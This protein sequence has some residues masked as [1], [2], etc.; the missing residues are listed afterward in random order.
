MHSIW[1]IARNTLAQ[2]LRMKIAV[3]VILLLLTLLPIMSMITE[4]DGTLIGQLQTFTSYGL[5]LISLL[6][7]VLTI[8][9]STYTLSNDMKRKYI[10][11]VIT[12]PAQ[13]IELV[14]GKVLGVMIFDVIL[15]AVF[16]VILYACTIFLPRLSDAPED[17]RIQADAEFFTSR[18][19][20]VPK[21]DKEQIEK[22][23][24]QRYQELKETSQLP[25]GMSYARIMS[26]LY[27][28]EVMNSKK[29][30][31]GETREWEFEN[32]R[33][34][35]NDASNQVIFV[36][37]KFNTSTTPLDERVFGLWQVGDLR[38]L[39]LGVE[40]QTP[41]YEMQRP[42]TVRTTHEFEVPADAIAFD[43]H[44]GI[45]FYN[46]PSLN[47]IRIIPE[48]LEI[49]FE[50]GSFSGNYFRAI[51]MILVELVFLSILGVSLSTWLSFPVAILVC[52]V[53][54][55]TALTNGFILD[56]IDGLGL[57]MGM[58]YSFT[59]KPLLW[60]L[61]KFDGLNN[62]NGYIVE[63]R[64]IGWVFLLAT[65]GTLVL[66]KG[67]FVFLAGLLIFSRREVGK[68]SA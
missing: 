21:V 23:A 14:A 67:F 16:G 4:G 3:V 45:A 1:A 63:A 28:Q 64:T 49:L 5:G 15:L 55:F 44:L 32:I 25:E 48:D 36:R 29:V 6:L 20:L 56:A 52:I 2:A 46:P 43:G 33:L 58:I 17:Q 51:L 54:Y 31:P 19:G 57:T 50:T 24:L 40:M 11:L 27:G 30:D 22:N 7:S 62:P 37:Y 39:R 53:V 68:V 60:F 18:V 12:K 35:Q 10:F 61:P 47:Q 34:I 8:A 42:D 65:S 41:I 59:I 9:V 26:E 66:I 38:Q 13:R